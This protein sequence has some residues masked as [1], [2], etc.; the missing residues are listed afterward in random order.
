MSF[1]E[2][3][4]FS[5]LFKEIFLI[6]WKMKFIPAFTRARHRSLQSARAIHSTPP[7]SIP[8]KSVLISSYHL[9]LR[10]P[11]FLFMSG[12]PTKPVRN[13]KITD[14]YKLECTCM[15]I[16]ARKIAFRPTWTSGLYICSVF[17]T[18]QIY[19][20][21]KTSVNNKKPKRSVRSSRKVEESRRKTREKWDTV[22]FT[23]STF[24]DPLR[25][26]Q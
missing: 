11:S 7:Y 24:K 23:W 5:Q 3:L 12:I 9:C 21:T 18:L 14:L 1:F 13:G 15:E 20:N 17:H 8:L 2:R 22:T 25:T 4:T 16:S 19:W 6:S 26:A 10:L